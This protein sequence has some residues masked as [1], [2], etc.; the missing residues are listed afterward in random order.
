MLMAVTRLRRHSTQRAV[1][2]RKLHYICYAD[3]FSLRYANASATRCLPMM[4][5]DAAAA[6]L[7]MLMIR[8]A[9]DAIFF[10]AA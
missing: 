5:L 8:H 10:R 6:M 3:A 1:A 4:P 7:M 2:M 9:I